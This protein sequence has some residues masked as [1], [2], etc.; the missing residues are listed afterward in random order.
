MAALD[1]VNVILFLVSDQARSIN[2]ALLPIDAGW[3]V[4]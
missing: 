4:I 2:G 1:V 3:S